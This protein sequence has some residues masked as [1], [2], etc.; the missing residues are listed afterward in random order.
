MFLT[1]QYTNGKLIDEICHILTKFYGFLMRW[2]SFKEI[3]KNKR[4]LAN[5]AHPKISKKV[6][7]K[8]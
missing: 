7:L 2:D 4:H 3:A 8:K 5:E 6:T 1:F